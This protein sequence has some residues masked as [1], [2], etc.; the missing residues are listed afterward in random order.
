M[1]DNHISEGAVKVLANSVG[2]IPGLSTRKH[3]KRSHLTHDA[4]KK[5][6]I[7]EKKKYR[8]EGIRFKLFAKLQNKKKKNAR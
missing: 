7:I 2:Q 1:R 5:I 3:L 8:P 6:N 4:E